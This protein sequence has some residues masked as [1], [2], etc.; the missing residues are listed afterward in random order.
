MTPSYVDHK[1]VDLSLQN[2]SNLS[3]NNNNENILKQSYYDI[4]MCKK[5]EKFRFER[6]H[7]CSI[8]RKCVEKFDH[9]CFILNNC[10]GK[11]NYFYFVSYLFIVTSFSFIIFI[12]TLRIFAKYKSQ[13]QLVRL[14]YSYFTYF[15]TFINDLYYI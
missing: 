12:M 1:Q 9:H 8:C 14:N 2:Q 13:L 10:I 7:H 11:K 6:S 15:K 4:E 3:V 5:C